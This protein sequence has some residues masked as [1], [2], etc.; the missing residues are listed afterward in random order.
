MKIGIIGAGMIGATLARRLTALGHEV[1][2]ANS[3]GPETL[4]EF[5]AET[6]ARAVTAVEAAQRL[7]ASRGF[8]RT[9]IEMTRELDDPAS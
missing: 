9:M 7:F 1:V 6:G 3:R 8:R 5:A 4:R 2:I